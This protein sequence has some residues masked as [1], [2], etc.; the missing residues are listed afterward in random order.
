[1][2]L[3]ESIGEAIDEIF[4][5]LGRDLE[6]YIRQRWWEFFD[7]DHDVELDDR[8]EIDRTAVWPPFW[9]HRV[10]LGGEGE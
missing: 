7:R 10:P 5:A 8:L 2:S 4:A 1:M 6:D 3:L 9:G